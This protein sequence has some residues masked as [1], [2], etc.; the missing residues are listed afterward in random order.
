MG[1]ERG[2]RLVLSP[3]LFFSSSI[4][5]GPYVHTSELFIPPGRRLPLR[6]LPDPIVRP[7]FG[8]ADRTYTFVFC[9]FSP[10]FSDHSSLVPLFFRYFFPFFFSVPGG[11]SLFSFSISAF[12]SFCWFHLAGLIFISNILLPLS[13]KQPIC[14]PFAGFGS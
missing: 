9:P 7:I 4:P 3:F 14:I 1:F 12:F 2:N 6:R 11:F 10:L 5:Y 8:T 13:H